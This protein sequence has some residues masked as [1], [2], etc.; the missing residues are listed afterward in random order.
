MTTGLCS[1]SS[2]RVL[3]KDIRRCY[4][5]LI[6]WDLLES[7][8]NCFSDILPWCREKNKDYAIAGLVSALPPITVNDNMK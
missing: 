4:S 2:H 6:L 5:K 3:L 8:F 7:V 1:D